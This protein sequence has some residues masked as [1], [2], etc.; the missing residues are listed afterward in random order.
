M[1][2]VGGLPSEHRHSLA[3]FTM[4]KEI[5]RSAYVTDLQAPQVGYVLTT[6]SAHPSMQA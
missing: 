1:S 4:Y 2:T 3:K 5:L 6:T